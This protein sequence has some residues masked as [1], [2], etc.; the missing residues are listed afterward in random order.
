V[1]CPT[2]LNLRVHASCRADGWRL[3]A[4]WLSCCMSMPIG[5]SWPS[6]HFGMLDGTLLRQQRQ[7]PPSGCRRDTQSRTKSRLLNTSRNS[8]RSKP[9]SKPNS[10]G[11]LRGPTTTASGG[12]GS[13]SKA[14]SM[15]WIYLSHQKSPPELCT[16]KSTTW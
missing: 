8:M 7:L 1:A 12:R 13:R 2:N 3:Q 11:L 5:E 15:E 6:T 14:L 10:S 4:S 16:K 9:S